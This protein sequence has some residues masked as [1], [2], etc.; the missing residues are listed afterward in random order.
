M[1]Y[2]GRPTQAVKTIMKRVVLVNSSVLY[3]NNNILFIL[4]LYDSDEMREEFLQDWMVEKMNRADSLDQRTN[5]TR[6]S[7]PAVREVCKQALDSINKTDKK[8]PIILN[9]LTFNLFPPSLT[10]RKNRN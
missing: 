4:W 8:C 10:T 2:E 3:R 1:P 9:K 6:R 7:R 5:G